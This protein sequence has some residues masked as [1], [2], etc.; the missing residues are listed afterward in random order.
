MKILV[1]GSNGLIG[2]SLVPFLTT[3]GHQVVRLVRSLKPVREPQVLWDPE[4]G[5]IRAEGLEGLDG[6]VHLAGESIAEGR[7]TPEKKAAIRKSRVEG[8]KLLCETLARLKNAPKVLV[9]ASAIGYYGS[10]GYETLTE[11]SSRGVGFLP[12]ICQEWEAASASASGRGIR[13]VLL[14]TG[15]VLSSAGGALAKMVPIFRMGAGGIL[16]DGR[17]VMSWVSIDDVVGI[18][19]HALMTESFSGAANAV[20]PNPVTNREF[21]KTLGR[22]LKRPTLFPA[23]AFALRLLVGEL[24]DEAL[25]ASAKVVPGKLLQSGYSF[26]Y[27]GLEEALRHVLAK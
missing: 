21:T 26:R 22:V 9:C 14:R 13:V 24:A 23:P 6:V 10:R 19:A 2:S 16:G 27:P 11:Q 12:E 25:L 5:D 1:T 4:G 8:T 20:A 18:I 3:G 7:W 15:I 17:Q